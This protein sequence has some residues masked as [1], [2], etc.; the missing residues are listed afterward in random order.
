MEVK[1]S[2]DDEQMSV[3]IGHRINVRGTSGSGKSTFARSLAGILDVPYV[4]I[5]HLH[6]KPGW[7]E[8]SPEEL[9][10]KVDLATSGDGWVLDG[11]Y[12]VIREIVDPRV[13]T[14]IWLDYPFWVVFGR[15]FVRT[16][17]RG[18]RKEVLWDGCQE[19]LWSQFF[20]RDSILW[21][22]IKTFRRRRRQC[23]EYMASPPEGVTAIRFGSP[24]EAEAFLEEVESGLLQNHQ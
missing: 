16:I 7:V 21:W 20:S 1:V 3:V 5:D 6:W 18:V 24:G 19:R 10:E 2:K 8:S 17:R 13:D 4:E 15:V 14:M 11:N 12:R 9:R 22:T 23:R